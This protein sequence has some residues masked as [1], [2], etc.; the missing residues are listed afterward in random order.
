MYKFHYDNIKNKYDNK[1]KLL[2]TDID[3]LIYKIKTED[4]Y[5]DFSSN[6]QMFDFSNYSTKSKY[7]DNSNKLVI[8]KMKDE[9]GS[10]VIEEF[11]RRKQKTYLFLVNNS[12]HKKQKAWI[13]KMLLQQGTMNKKMYYWI[14]NL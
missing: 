13:K 8:G 12:E 10:I 2:F 7:Y 14:M 6:K 4:V 5:E 11:V 1:L 3:S 9:T